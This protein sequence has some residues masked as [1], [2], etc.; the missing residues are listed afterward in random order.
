MFKTRL[1]FLKG[2]LTRDRPLG[3]QFYQEE[4]PNATTPRHSFCVHVF[5]LARHCVRMT[6]NIST[7]NSYECME[8]EQLRHPVITLPTVVVEQDK[9]LGGAVTPCS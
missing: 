4:N 3:F 8:K 2:R 1:F 9:G 7:L 5:K 6:S